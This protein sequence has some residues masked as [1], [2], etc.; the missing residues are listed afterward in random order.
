M[1]EE[2]DNDHMF[3]HDTGKYSVSALDYLPDP[4]NIEGDTEH[5]LSY[6]LCFFFKTEEER[7][8]IYRLFKDGMSRIPSGEKL[9]EFVRRHQQE[10][11]DESTKDIEEAFGF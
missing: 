6:K 4:P 5:G 11:I 1:T 10:E 2:N 3:K 8:E 9:L 7:D